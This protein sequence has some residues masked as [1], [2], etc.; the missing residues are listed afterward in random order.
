MV[1]A[2]GFNRV[3]SDGP[4]DP[5]LHLLRI[6]SLDG[7]PY[8]VLFSH[9]CHPVTI[10]QR[11]A[12][13]TA[14]SA[15]WPG[16]VACRLQE[17]GYGEAFFRLGACGD[18]DPVVAWHG[19]EFEGTSLSA[20]VVTQSLLRLLRS[21]D[22]TTALRL[23][24]AREIVEL[25]L[26]P[27]EEKDIATALSEAQT[28]YGSIHVTDT[29]SQDAAWQDFYRSW[30][31]AMRARLPAQSGY[32]SIPLAALSVNGEAWL[33]LPGEVFTSLSQRIQEGSPFPVTIVT[34]LAAHFIGYIPDRDDFAA[35][36]YASTLVPRILRLPPYSPAVG[37]A[38][39]DRAI[40]LLGG[41]A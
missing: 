35:G 36:G 16:Q 19:F 2:L 14:I 33:H 17:E 18:I 39:V 26:Q 29:D 3:R 9:G 23:R 30:A 28:Q 41:L 37:D 12:A 13:G 1:Q 24:I 31:E 22:T 7:E 8:V 21:I 11:T 6:D 25:P 38:L 27:L 15:D 32:L 40:H 20:E 5:G 10:D 34:S 4:L